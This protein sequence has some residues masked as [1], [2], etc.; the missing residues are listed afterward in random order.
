[1][2]NVLSG[3]QNPKMEGVHFPFVYYTLLFYY[4]QLKLV[5]FSYLLL[6]WK[7]K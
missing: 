4:I 2:L 3:V 7:N 1:M 6:K 5:T